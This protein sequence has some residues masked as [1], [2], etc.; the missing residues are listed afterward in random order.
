[1]NCRVNWP[2]LMLNQMMQKKRRYNFVQI[3]FSYFANF[4]TKNIFFKS[5]EYKIL[6]CE[7]WTRRFKN[8]KWINLETEIKKTYKN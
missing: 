8:Y 5:A 6:K 7:E 4:V 1:M 3:F 2:G